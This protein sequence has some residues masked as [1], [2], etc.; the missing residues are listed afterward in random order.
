[1]P[2]SMVLVVAA[3]LRLLGIKT[4]LVECYALHTKFLTDSEDIEARACT[5]YKQ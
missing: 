1:M 4:P 3:V 2:F 5:K